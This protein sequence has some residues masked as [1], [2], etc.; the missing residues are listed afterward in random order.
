M[1]EQ[2]LKLGKFMTDQMA[3][4]SVMSD[5][6]ALFRLLRSF[7]FSSLYKWSFQNQSCIILQITLTFISCKKLGT[8]ESVI[9]HE[10][11]PLVQ[12]LRSNKLFLNETKTELIVFRFPWKHLTREPDI[13]INNYKLKLHSHIKYLGIFINKICSGIS[14]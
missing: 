13:R 4:Y 2:S 8:I 9:N 6:R 14:K 12:W 11:K 1:T 5:E 7:A 10:L 3:I